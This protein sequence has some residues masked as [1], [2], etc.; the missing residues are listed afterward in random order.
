MLLPQS[1]YPADAF[2][3][4]FEPSPSAAAE[5]LFNVGAAV[6]AHL[7]VH[8]SPTRRAGSRLTIIEVAIEGR[9]CT[10]VIPTVACFPD[11]HP[12]DAQTSV[13]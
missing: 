9:E 7:D 5:I 1:V 11:M 8:F 10:F 13:A 4:K 12:P 3:R 6:H 2:N